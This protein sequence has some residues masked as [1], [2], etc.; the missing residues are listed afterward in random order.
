[1]NNKFIGKILIIIGI[2]GIALKIFEAYAVIR[3]CFGYNY[4]YEI[5]SILIPILFII[6]GFLKYNNFFS[7]G[8]K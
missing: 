6:V 8:S 3:G 5:L 1:M 2:L 4:T 7:I